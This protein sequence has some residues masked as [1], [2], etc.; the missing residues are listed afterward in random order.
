MFMGALFEAAVTYGVDPELTPIS[1]ARAAPAG[2]QGTIEGLL[3]QTTGIVSSDVV[4]DPPYGFKVIIDDGSG[5]I[6]IFVHMRGT[7]PLVDLSAVNVGDRVEVVGLGFQYDG[8]Y[9]INPR[10]SADFK[11]VNLK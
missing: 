10:S 11:I 7:V 4:E 2:T 1:E 8:T 6:Q 3:I 5:E 9:E